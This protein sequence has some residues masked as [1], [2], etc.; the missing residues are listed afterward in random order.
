[1]NKITAPVASPQAKKVAAAKAGANEVQPGAGKK[2]GSIADAASPA[3]APKE[4][5]ARYASPGPK[6][7]AKLGR[8][9]AGDGGA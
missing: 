8:N 7:T 5:K 4:Y 2:F 6:I 1:M 9:P 3:G